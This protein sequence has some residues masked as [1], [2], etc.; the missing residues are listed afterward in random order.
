MSKFL[1]DVNLPRY[2]KYFHSPDFEFVSDIDTRMSDQ[3]IWDY[4]CEKSLIILTKDSDFYTRCVLSTNPAKVIHFQFGNYTLHQLH[5]FFEKNWERIK[6]MIEKST[7]L[8]VDED[9]IR[10]VL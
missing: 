9:E 3:K 6:E 2:F 4:A 7:L 8:I 10:T 5:I 1:V